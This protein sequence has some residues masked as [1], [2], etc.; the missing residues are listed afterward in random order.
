MGGAAQN[1]AEGFDPYHKWLGIPPEQRPIHHYRL[2]GLSLFE[3]DADVI[4]NAADQRMG[5][6][7][8][9]QAGRHAQASQRLLN[10]IAAARVCLLNPAK[11]AQYDRRLREELAV[12]TIASGD[13]AAR[14]SGREMDWRR[15]L[16]NSAGQ[17]WLLLGGAAAL[18]AFGALLVV[19]RPW[20][21]A[22]DATSEGRPSE[23]GE[24]RAPVKAAGDDGVPASSD[25]SDVAATAAA[26]RSVAAR[27]L[28]ARK[29]DG[30]TANATHKTID[31]SSLAAKPSAE[32]TRRQASAIAMPRATSEPPSP[33]EELR[34]TSAT[35]T[36]PPKQGEH[37]GGAAPAQPK[38][39]PGD[40]ALAQLK[41]SFGR[42]R[43]AAEFKAVA[44]TALQQANRAASGGRPD[45]GVR[46][47]TWG[48]VAARKADDSE[49]VGR[50]TLRLL[51]LRE[52]SAE[53]PG[54]AR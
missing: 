34:P 51:D 36:S 38:D 7:R 19:G 43:S 10:E 31:V 40:E 17:R 46:L 25:V 45:L 42:A 24:P 20:Q 6:V 37:S 18:L 2:L 22:E 26:R 3:S 35:A 32:E 27:P 23:S 12:G 33:K 28:T 8:A 53:R 47:L 9:F 4:A 30:S 13:S 29:P 54:A 39:A 21:P 49:L 1:A 41:E 44:E 52:P 11:K 5:H 48:L 14:A 15:L 16:R 50:V